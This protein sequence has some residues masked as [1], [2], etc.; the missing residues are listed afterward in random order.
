MNNQKTK[1]TAKQKR[2][3]GQRQRQPPRQPQRQ[4]QQL[5]AK[6]QARA[7]ATAAATKAQTNVMQG[8]STEGAVAV[9][10]ASRVAGVR[11]AVMYWFDAAGGPVDHLIARWLFLRAL[12]LIYLSAF[13]ALL[14]QVRGLIGAQGILPAGEFLGAL[15]QLGWLRFWYAPTLLWVSG[16]DRWLMTLCWAGLIASLLM[17]AN[18]WPRVML[19]VCFLSFL[20]FVAAARDFSGYQSDGMLL[21]AG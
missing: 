11:R 15:H 14:Y 17:V 20:S 2:Q 16:S 4:Q 6:A 5:G 10:Q 21:E 19:L 7:T 1:A 3:Q 8:Q 12:G 13:L 18:L 9:E